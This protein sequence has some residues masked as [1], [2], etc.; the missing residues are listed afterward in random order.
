MAGTGM[1]YGVDY[2]KPTT[3]KAPVNREA[4][5]QWF[6]PVPFVKGM[7]EQIAGTH[8]DQARLAG[9]AVGLD[10]IPESW[11]SNARNLTA[12]G[13]ALKDDPAGTVG[14]MAFGPGGFYN[15]ASMAAPVPKGVGYMR[16]PPSGHQLLNRV[17]KDARK[18]GAYA[19]L[20][21]L[22]PNIRNSTNPG[23]WAGGLP[24]KDGNVVLR[25]WADNDSHM[26]K[27]WK[28]ASPEQLKQTSHTTGGGGGLPASVTD[29]GF[30]VGNRRTLSE[31]HIPHKQFREGIK[32]RDAV[33]GN[34]AEGEFVLNPKWA[35][36]YHKPQYSNWAPAQKQLTPAP[37]AEIN[38][39]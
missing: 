23:L 16:K 13:R 3:G 31:F 8:L 18:S 29:I 15:L 28:P 17:S 36:Q 33:F 9:K 20:D 27:D 5:K 12:A 24:M 11:P 10:M 21:S 6:N 26:T 35:Q 2:T 34:M 25:R 19:H 14:N 22:D 30:E 1:G 37:P 32:K 38:L 39:P 7:G 4:V